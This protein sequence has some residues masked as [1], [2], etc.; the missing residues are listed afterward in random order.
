LQ[1]LQA[2]GTPTL[3]SR[4]LAAEQVVWLV[5]GICDEWLWCAIAT[6]GASPSI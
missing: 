6:P 4:R 2:T 5:I 1:A 3:R